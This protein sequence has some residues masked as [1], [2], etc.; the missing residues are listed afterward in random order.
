MDS[1]LAEASSG[2]AMVM[3]A[4][5]VIFSDLD[6]TLLGPGGWPEVEARRAVAGILERD[7][8]LILVTSKT[9]A[10]V[11]PMHA[12]L[13]LRDP[14]VVENGGAVVLPPGWGRWRGGELTLGRPYSFLRALLRPLRRSHGLRGFGDMTVQEIAEHTG[15]DLAAARLAKVRRFTEP[16]LVE[17]ESQAK[18][19]RRAAARQHCQVCRGGIFHHLMGAEHDKGLAVRLLLPMLKAKFGQLRTIAI[20]DAENDMPMLEVADC[21]LRLPELKP[22][23]G[24]IGGRWS[25]WIERALE[26]PGTQAG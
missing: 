14:Y 26:V 12:Q 25:R 20:G 17:N 23:T 2:Q 3:G 1:M 7:V 6:G 9:A 22:G 8:S 10:E 5:T 13:G 21:P 16:V 18:A 19:L 15:L 11:G 4:K 24:T